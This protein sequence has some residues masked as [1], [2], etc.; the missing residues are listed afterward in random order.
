M[1]AGAVPAGG[2]T[3]PDTASNVMMIKKMT[4]VSFIVLPLIDQVLIIFFRTAEFLHFLQPQSMFL[5]PVIMPLPQ[6][7]I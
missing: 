1:A 2:E 3:H 4:T 6:H 7:L 5:S